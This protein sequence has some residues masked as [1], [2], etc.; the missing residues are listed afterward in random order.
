MLQYSDLILLP[1]FEERLEFLR[2]ESLPSE[3]TFD[4]LRQLNQKFYNSR[5]WKTVRS[6]VISRDLG[7]D[8]A[9]PGREIVGRV[10]VHHMNPLTPKDLLYHSD[11]ALDP[12]FLITTSYQTH[13]AIHFGS[14]PLEPL[15]DRKSGDTVLWQTLS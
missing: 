3:I 10:L 13:Q 15:V 11:D 6:S 8:L 14:K 2:T 5:S 7:F 12:D 1:T 4:Q 9:I